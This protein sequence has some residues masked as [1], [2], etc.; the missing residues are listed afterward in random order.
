MQVNRTFLSVLEAPVSLWSI[1]L[2]RLF[3]LMLMS[4]EYLCGILRTFVQTSVLLWKLVK[5]TIAF[6]GF[7]TSRYALFPNS[8]MEQW[9]SDFHY[10]HIINNFISLWKQLLLL[11]NRYSCPQARFMAGLLI[12]LP[13]LPLNIFPLK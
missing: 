4:R 11:S 9:D 2:I 6:P 5:L 7:L 3:C 10:A 13:T 8:L 12:I 1:I